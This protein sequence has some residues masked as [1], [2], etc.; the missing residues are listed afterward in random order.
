MAER[1]TQDHANRRVLPLGS[2]GETV[3]ASA[4]TT[5]RRASDK[6]RT[7]LVKSHSLGRERQARRRVT[8]L[9]EDES[10][11]ARERGVPVPAVGLPREE[12]PHPGEVSIVRR[13]VF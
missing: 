11:E 3:E 13:F 10:E 12:P 4:A 2:D 9:G 1:K 5:G 6:L 8:P 7:A